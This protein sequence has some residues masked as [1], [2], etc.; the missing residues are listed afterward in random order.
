M[1]GSVLARPSSMSYRFCP[2]DPRPNP[3]CSLLKRE[4]DRFTAICHEWCL[5]HQSS[6]HQAGGESRAQRLLQVGRTDLGTL[7]QAKGAVRDMTHSVIHCAVRLCEAGCCG[8]RR[9]LTSGERASHDWPHT[10]RNQR[11]QPAIEKQV[12]ELLTCGTS[13]SSSCLQ[14]HQ[15]GLKEKWV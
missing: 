11:P 13:F 7:S 4:W 6:S 9:L 15:H 2:A 1:P 10:P 8:P 5:A 12:S 3:K 14:I